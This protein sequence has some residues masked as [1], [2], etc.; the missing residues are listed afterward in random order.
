MISIINTIN[1][2]KTEIDKMKSDI[3]T[4]LSILQNQTNNDKNNSFSQANINDEI[5]IFLNKTTT[6][7]QNNRFNNIF[8]EQ[9]IIDISN[10]TFIISECNKQKWKKIIINAQ[11]CSQMI[12]VE[13]SENGINIIN[14]EDIKFTN[15]IISNLL[16][17]EIFP[18]I[19][20]LYDLKNILHLCFKVVDAFILNINPNESLNIYTKQTL[21]TICIP[22]QNNNIIVFEKNTELPLNN[23]ELLIYCGNKENYS[24]N[25][26]YFIIININMECY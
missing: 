8:I 3:K 12:E 24:I 16:N 21:F 6:D 20:K 19:I 26:G 9:Q 4:I 7:I 17:T 11:S 2:Y 18:K 10:S 25:K 15:K 1:E 22:F 23:G 13:S 5:N 14:L